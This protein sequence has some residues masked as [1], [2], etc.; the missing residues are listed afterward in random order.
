MPRTPVLVPSEHLP[1]PSTTRDMLPSYAPDPMRKSVSLELLPS[2]PEEEE[3]PGVETESH[4]ST[5]SA[6][7]QQ[8]QG[9]EQKGA[10]SMWVR[11]WCAG[12]D[13]PSLL[14]TTCR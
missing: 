7:K 1:S 9:L 4:E 13:H 12:L 11:Y 10:D 2:A 8:F 5:D 14:Q 3:T 6:G